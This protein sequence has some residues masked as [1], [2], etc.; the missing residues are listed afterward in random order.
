MADYKYDMKW[1]PK[2]RKV[3]L[4]DRKTKQQVFAGTW[5]EV[6]EFRAQNDEEE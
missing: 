3:L 2:A 4:Y 6:R 1:D 5:D